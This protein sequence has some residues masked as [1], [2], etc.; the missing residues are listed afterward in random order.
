M[1]NDEVGG[2]FLLMP[3]PKLKLT[4]QIR[5]AVDA[6]GMSR[7]RICKH[8]GLAESTMSRFMAGG[9][10]GQENIDALGELLG[11]SITVNEPAKSKKKG[12]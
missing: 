9:G 10:L 11:L 8:L 12:S 7:Y 3:T 6:S 5:A 2:I 4:E 1:P